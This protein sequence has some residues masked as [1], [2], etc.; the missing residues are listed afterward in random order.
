MFE[1][2]SHV[3]CCIGCRDLGYERVFYARGGT[4]AWHL[5]ATVWHYSSY[6]WGKGHVPDPQPFALEEVNFERGSAELA[7]AGLL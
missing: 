4:N 6:Q 7:R 2:T 5:D 1:L 3:C